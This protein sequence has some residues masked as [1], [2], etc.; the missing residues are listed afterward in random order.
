MLVFLLI[1]TVGCSS[2]ETHRE[3][4]ELSILIY[5]DCKV[6]PDYLKLGLRPYFDYLLTPCDW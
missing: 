6:L 4:F 5:R 3:G 2:L 1:V